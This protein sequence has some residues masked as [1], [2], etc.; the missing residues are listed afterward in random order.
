MTQEHRTGSDA[1]ATSPEQRW[2]GWSTWV[3][4]TLTVGIDAVSHGHS[5]HR[6]TWLL[7]GLHC[8]RL[9]LGAVNSPPA[10][11]PCL[12]HSAYA[13]S[14][15]SDDHGLS[16]AKPKLSGV[17]AQKIPGIDAYV[18][19]VPHAELGGNAMKYV[20]LKVTSLRRSRQQ[21]LTPG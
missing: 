11:W 16:S 19:C 1:S 17:E 8:L 14:L 12:L 21:I 6:Y 2:R 10:A 18:N 13:V 5:R 15:A 9:E 7:R 20:A 3:D 4:W